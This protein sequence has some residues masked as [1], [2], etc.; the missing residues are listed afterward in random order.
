[1][2]LVLVRR[3]AAWG[4]VRTHLWVC[5][6]GGEAPPAEQHASLGLA[7]PRWER[8]VPRGPW[9]KGARRVA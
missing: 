3:M 1:M 8:A 7:G 5:E 2:K 4:W 9:P 6:G